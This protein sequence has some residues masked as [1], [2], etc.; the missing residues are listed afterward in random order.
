MPGKAAII[1]LRLRL[2]YRCS[3]EIKDRVP[4]EC[5]HC[6]SITSLPLT[7]YLLDCNA[8]DAIRPPEF[9]N[10]HADSPQRVAVAA[11]YVQILLENEDSLET[12]LNAPPPR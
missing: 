5:K 3:C 1:I 4:R 6:E 10:I 11:R 9:T 7:H 2:G 12:L 8:L